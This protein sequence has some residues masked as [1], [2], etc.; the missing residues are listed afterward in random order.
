MLGE[1]GDPWSVSSMLYG[2]LLVD[3]RALSKLYVRIQLLKKYI[4]DFNI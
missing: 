1:G 4:K 3:S 2:H